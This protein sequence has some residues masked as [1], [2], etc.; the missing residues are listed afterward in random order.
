MDTSF[1]EQQY[2]LDVNGYLVN[3]CAPESVSAAIPELGRFDVPVRG[4]YANGFEKLP[5]ERPDFAATADEVRAG[6]RREYF[7]FAL[8]AGSQLHSREPVAR[9][10]FVFE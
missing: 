2:L 7:C 1:E 10:V 4:G 8:H 9:S 6:G 3:C 5:G